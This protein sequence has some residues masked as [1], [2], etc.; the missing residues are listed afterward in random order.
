ME[1]ANNT[2]ILCVWELYFFPKPKK[3]S[4]FIDFRSRRDFDLSTSIVKGTLEAR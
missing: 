1:A 3:E 2:S 4:R